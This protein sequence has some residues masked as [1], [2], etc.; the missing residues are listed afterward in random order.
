MA[1]RA[2]AAY[3]LEFNHIE[4]DETVLKRSFDE[5]EV[6]ASSDSAE[7]GTMIAQDGHELFSRDLCHICPSG[8]PMVR[9]GRHNGYQKEVY[10]CPGKLETLWAGFSELC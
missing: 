8:K 5:L 6:E 9:A 7:E 4:Q 2:A 10:C 3:K 1:A